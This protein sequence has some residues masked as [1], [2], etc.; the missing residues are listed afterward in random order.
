MLTMADVAPT[1]KT[2]ETYYESM[3]ELYDGFVGT[4][5]SEVSLTQQMMKTVKAAVLAG[6]S[7]GDEAFPIIRALMYLD[8]LVI[9][10]HPEVLLI[11]SMGPYLDEF[12]VKL[13]IEATTA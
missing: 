1:G 13:G 7:F 4:S 3:F 2:L 11:K 12:R 8:G 6:C 5:V 9:R 10:T